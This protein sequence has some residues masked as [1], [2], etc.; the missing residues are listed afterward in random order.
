[1]WAFRGWRLNFILQ[2]LRITKKKKKNGKIYEQQLC[3]KAIR[4]ED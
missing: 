4:K 2:V 3:K 1:M